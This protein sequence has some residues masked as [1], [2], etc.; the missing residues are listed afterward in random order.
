VVRQPPLDAVASGGERD[1]PLGQQLQ[2]ARWLIRNAQQRFT[3]IQRVAECI[4]SHQKA[5]FDYGEIALKPLVL[6]DVADELG[7]HESTIS[8]AT[9]NKYMATPRGIFEF[10]HF[11]PRELSTESGGTCSAAAVRALLKEMISKEN[12]RDPLSD[13]SLAK[14]LADQGV[15]VARRTVAK[16]RHL[17]KVPPAELRRQV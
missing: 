10:K 17:M 16:Y 2:E 15:I 5:F 11:F 14:M 7:L 6:R 1:S 8:R 13:V 3:T 4:V 9:G 12:T